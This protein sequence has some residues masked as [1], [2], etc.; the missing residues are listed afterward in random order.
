MYLKNLIQRMSDRSYRPGEIKIDNLFESSKTIYTTAYEEVRQL[1]KIELLPE[2]FEL[3]QKRELQEKKHEIYFIIGFIA[4]N[5][6]NLEATS[7]LL[8]ALSTEKEQ[9]NLVCILDRLAE[10]YKPLELD[11][12]PIFNL[13]THRN[14]QIRGASFNALTNSEHKVE[15][16][17]LDL[18]KTSVNR[19][20][21]KRLIWAIQYI[22]TAKAIP[23][24]EPHI[25]NR[26]PD[27]KYAAKI[28]INVIMIREQ[29][30]DSEIEKKNKRACI[31]FVER[32]DIFFN[33]PLICNSETQIRR[34]S[35]SI[36]L[37]YD[38]HL[39]F[40]YMSTRSLKILRR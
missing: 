16:F 34:V 6:N 17:L 23:I 10:L 8:K 27:I 36:Y 38:L 37:S 35:N 21:I 7:F 32:K 31:I 28:A 40:P 39:N 19:D 11:L 30:S 3:I 13:T 15:Q 26:K 14:W 5:T 1:S 18:L 22:G 4:K 25:K 33:T 2:L 20:D 29:F 9:S 12:T 24:I